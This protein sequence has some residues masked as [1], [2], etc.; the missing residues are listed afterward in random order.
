LVLSTL[1]GYVTRWRRDHPEAESGREWVAVEVAESGAGTGSG[2]VLLLG[3][4]RRIEIG[5]GFDAVTLQEL[6]RALEPG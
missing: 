4:G 1:A 2:L 6:L 3:R 5:R